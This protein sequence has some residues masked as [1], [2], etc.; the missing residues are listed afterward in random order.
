[1]VQSDGSQIYIRLAEHGM[2][3]LCTAEDGGYR[4]IIES[5]PIKELCEETSAEDEGSEWEIP[6]GFSWSIDDLLGGA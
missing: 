5:V 1:M 3:F 2:S 4:L 6:E